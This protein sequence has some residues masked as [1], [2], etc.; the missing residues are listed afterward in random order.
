[1]KWKW[2]GGASILAA[3]L[4]IKFGA[5]LVPVGFGIAAVALLNWWRVRT[6]VHQSK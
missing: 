2:F 1:M 5:P 4:L 3:G 6:G